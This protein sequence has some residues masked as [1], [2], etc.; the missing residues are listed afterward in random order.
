MI[1]FTSLFAAHHG[2]GS[3]TGGGGKA[4]DKPESPAD[5]LKGGKTSEADKVEVGSNP[6]QR[7]RDAEARTTDEMPRST[8]NPANSPAEARDAI[9]A[10]EKARAAGKPL[11]EVVEFAKQ[12]PTFGEWFDRVQKSAQFNG[13]PIPEPSEQWE[14]AYA[15]EI[16]P[17]EACDKL[18]PQKPDFANSNPP[19]TKPVDAGKKAR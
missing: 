16:L 5:P 3:D 15:A 19:E 10:R 17:A 6:E 13:R 1:A 4:K 18:C 7:I 2:E 8:P 14:K 12:Y 11:D 9:E